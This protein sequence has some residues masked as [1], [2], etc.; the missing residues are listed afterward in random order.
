MADDMPNKYSYDAQT[1][2]TTTQSQAIGPDTSYIKT[3]P[4]ILKIAEIV[5]CQGHCVISW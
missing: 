5:S 2:S 3:L 4:G 1:T